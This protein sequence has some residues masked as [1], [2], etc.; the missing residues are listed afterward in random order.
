MKLPPVRRPHGRTERT[1]ALL[2]APL[3]AWAVLLLAGCGGGVD[4]SAASG[5]APAAGPPSAPAPAPPSDPR[6]PGDGTEPSPPG[7]E[8]PPER[9]RNGNVIPPTGW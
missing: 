7:G 6:P 3:V 2:A 4:G 8:P 9:D 5:A 1:G